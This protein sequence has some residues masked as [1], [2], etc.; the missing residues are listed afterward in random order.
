M[1]TIKGISLV[2]N[3]SIYADYFSS[4]LDDTPISNHRTIINIPY[5]HLEIPNTSLKDYNTFQIVQGVQFPFDYETAQNKIEKNKE[6]IERYY[7]EDISF[8]LLSSADNEVQDNISIGS[9][10]IKADLV[11]YILPFLIFII[12]I[13]VF[14]MTNILYKDVEITGAGKNS[15]GDYYYPI[16]LPSK[17]T[18]KVINVTYFYLLFQIIC[19]GLVLYAYSK[20][21]T[22]GIYL[23]YSLVLIL[24]IFLLLRIVKLLKSLSN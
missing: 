14:I 20:N 10:S 1:D 19:F 4:V 11:Y 24:N 6:K 2:C 15:Y 18:D 3:I 13:T 23:L 16:P 21:V 17:I 7:S 22:I 5:R 8:M 12:I 9:L